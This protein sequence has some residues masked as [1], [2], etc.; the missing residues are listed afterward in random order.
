MDWYCTLTEHLL[1]NFTANKSL[2]PT[3]KPLR[4]RVFELYKTI[5]RY[6]MN[7]V[8]SYNDPQ[9]FVFL[10]NLLNG[11]YWDEELEK[12]KIAEKILLD[13]WEQYNKIEAKELSS[14]LVKLAEN[15]EKQLGDIHQEL[16][17]FIDLQQKIQADSKNKECLRDLRVVNPKDDMKRIENEKEELFDGA[18]KWILEDQT[19]G[20][21]TNW[22]ETDQPPC[23][24]LWI[25]G[26]AGTGKTMLLI[27]IIRELSDQPA[28]LAPTLSYFFCQ[29]QGKTDSPLNDAMATLRSL[30]WMLVIQQ[31]RLR[32]STGRLRVFSKVSFHRQECIHCSVSNT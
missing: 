27:G 1:K 2:E 15:M 32:A 24:L 19:Y 18:Y 9:V 5:L 21:F 12:V 16:R 31:P 25:N 13:D 11:N 26:L 4:E 10:R 6:Q 20:E 17:E 3:L 30:I 14:Q 22:D 23:R 28:V 8:C 7:S 29:G